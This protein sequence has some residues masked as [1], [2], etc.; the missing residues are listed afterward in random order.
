M[1]TFETIDLVML[2]VLI[3][4]LVISAFF[5]ASET[6]LFGLAES[7]RL[8]VRRRNPR[9]SRII[10]NL[11]AQPRMLLITVILGNMTVNTLYFVVS[12]VLSMRMADNLWAATLIGVIT[13]LVII[14]F[15]EVIPKLLGA[16]LRDRVAI[17]LAPAMLAVHRGIGPFRTVI[18][19]LVIAPL[20]RL[21]APTA[22]PRELDREEL[23]EMLD[24]SA[25]DGVIDDL[26]QSLLRE[27]VRMKGLRVSDVM[28][29]RV[30]MVSISR[31][32]S[33]RD[34]E[35]LAE[36]THLSEIVVRARSGDSIDG[37]C[38]MRAFLLDPRREDAVLEDHV[39]SARFIPELSSLEHL[40]EHF[41]QTRTSTS[42][43]VDEWG[44][45]A[46]V[47]TIEDLVEELIGDI[48]GLGE[49]AVP[50]PE[51]LEDGSWRISGSTHVDEW[52]ALFGRDVLPPRVR[53][54]GG[55]FM[56]LLGRE[57]RSGDVITLGNL[58]CTVET[59][60]GGRVL[61]ALVRVVEPDTSEPDADGGDA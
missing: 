61:T 22:R 16:S 15:G 25:R 8:A 58:L 54:V 35:R 5:S 2:L 48:V 33:R 3:P 20:A 41:R 1:P 51:S 26:E 37:L 46:G 57:P 19:R 7:D 50:P 4:L 32:D 17:I 18:D 39:R 47:V 55:L 14:I 52:A 45:T 9:V 44:G 27:V 12:S 40:L 24:L 30:D 36:R 34:I 28:T 53:T 10:D 43:V 42:V 21:T 13:V 29:P 56:D 38:S 49:Q 11:L 31:D 23:A 59:L 60:D 6:V